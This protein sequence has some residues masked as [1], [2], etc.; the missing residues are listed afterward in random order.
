LAGVADLAVAHSSGVGG[1]AVTRLLGPGRVQD[2]ALLARTSP[3]AMVPLGV[4]QILIHGLD[5]TVVPPSMSKT[6]A[7]R[8]GHAGDDARYLPL[9]GIGHR[10]VIDPRTTA[11]DEAS[12]AL[13]E[14]FA[15]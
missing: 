7:A 8:A 6:Y 10:D 12:A 13:E 1:D 2:Q 4:P 11:W 3:A 5:D 14:L 15:G 9:P